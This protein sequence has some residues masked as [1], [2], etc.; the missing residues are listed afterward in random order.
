VSRIF[1]RRTLLRGL[2]G[3]DPVSCYGKYDDTTLFGTDDPAII[4]NPG[5]YPDLRAS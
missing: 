3:T 4:K 2:G 5:E 1:N